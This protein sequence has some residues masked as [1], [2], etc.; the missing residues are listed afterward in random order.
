MTGAEHTDRQGPVDRLGD[1]GRLEESA[2]AQFG[3]DGRDLTRDRLTRF[4]D[5]KAHDGDLAFEARVVHPVIETPALERVVDVAGPVR[6][7]DD[8]GRALGPERP[9]F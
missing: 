1:A 9:E 3:D 2:P 8:D 6:G 7:Q 4:G 5:A